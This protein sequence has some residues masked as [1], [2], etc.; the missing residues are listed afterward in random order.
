MLKR[1]W[2][3]KLVRFICVGATNTVNDLLILNILVFVFH[4]PVLVANVFSATISIT[5][6]YF[7]NHHLVFRIVEPHEFARFRRFFLV[8]G[9]SILLVQTVTIAVAMHLLKADTVVLDRMLDEAGFRH[10]TAEAVNVNIAK[11]TAVLA[12]MGWNFILY[13]KIVFKKPLKKDALEN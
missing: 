3:V 6:S 12:G 1:L 8:T 9:L 11:I 13:H 2:D 10:L 5:I 4:L 7:L